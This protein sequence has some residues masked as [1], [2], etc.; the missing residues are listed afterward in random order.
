LVTYDSVEV[1]ELLDGSGLPL[2][3]ALALITLQAFQ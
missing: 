3:Q 1:L 2:S